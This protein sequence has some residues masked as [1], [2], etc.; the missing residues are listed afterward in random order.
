[1]A[2]ELGA[3]AGCT[4]LEESGE[5]SSRVEGRL[6]VGRLSVCLVERDWKRMWA[7]TL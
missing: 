7:H 5:E 1:M 6:D 4:L 3:I 2:A